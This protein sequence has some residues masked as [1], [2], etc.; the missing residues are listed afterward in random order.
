[1]KKRL[2]AWKA[3]GQLLGFA[4]RPQSARMRSDSSST[5]CR[6]H[7]TEKREKQLTGRDK[8]RGGEGRERERKKPSSLEVSHVCL[9][10]SHARGS[11]ICRK[12]ASLDRGAVKS[13]GALQHAERYGLAEDEQKKQTVRRRRPGKAIRIS[14]WITLEENRMKQRSLTLP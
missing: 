14:A 11:S 13:S 8:V 7:R 10:A 3:S 1:M 12:C 9:V 6:P 5:H 2:D 4:R